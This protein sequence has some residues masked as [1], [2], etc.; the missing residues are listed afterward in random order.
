MC[1]LGVRQRVASRRSIDSRRVRLCAW[2]WGRRGFSVDGRLAGGFFRRR[3][4]QEDFSRRRGRTEASRPRTNPKTHAR[5]CSRRS[6]TRPS[7]SQVRAPRPVRRGFPHAPHVTSRGARSARM[8]LDAPQLWHVR[9]RTPARADA[10]AAPGRPDRDCFGRARGPRGLDDFAASRLLAS[11]CPG[12]A[13]LPLLLPTPCRTPPEIAASYAARFAGSDR[14]ECASITS[15]V[16]AAAASS[17][18]TLWSG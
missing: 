9:T 18:S 16:W 11:D 7:I 8:G 14:T 15:R 17:L 2:R 13:A 5:A 6:S 1:H 3:R 4:N 10:F 12:R